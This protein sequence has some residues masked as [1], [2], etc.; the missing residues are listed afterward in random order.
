MYVIKLARGPYWG[1]F[2]KF[3]LILQKKNDTNIPQ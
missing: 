3:F 1:I 2:V